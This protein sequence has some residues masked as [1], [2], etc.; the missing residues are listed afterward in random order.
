EP[1]EHRSA[2][3]AGV[4]HLRAVHEAVDDEGVLSWLEE[5]R[6]ADL[7]DR[8]GRAQI[9]RALLENVVLRERA[10]EGQAAAL[11]R[12]LLGPAAQFDLRLKQLVARGTILLA[13]PREP[14]RVQGNGHGGLLPGGANAAA[15]VDRH[16]EFK[17]AARPGAASLRPGSR[18][19]GEHRN[20]R[21]HDPSGRVAQLA[22]QW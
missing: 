22:E 18:L 19:T 12:D 13:L 10:A 4:V 20:A 8:L 15:L 1:V 11:R 3:R 9:A 21:R 6:E 16:G 2:H 7:L 14:H 5:L 17:T